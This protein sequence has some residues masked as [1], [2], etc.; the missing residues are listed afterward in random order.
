[1][2]YKQTIR[3]GEVREIAKVGRQIKIINCESTLQLRV[4]LKGENLLDTEVRSGFDVTFSK[5]DSITLQSDQE[6]RIEVWASPNPLGYKAPTKGSNSNLSEIVDH[7]GG[8]QQIL[9]FE[10]NRVAI[11]LFSDTEPFWY[12]GQGV[13]IANGIP[14]AAGVPHKIEGSGEFHI[15]INKPP[16]FGITGVLGDI[17]SEYSALLAD[18]PQIVNNGFIDNQSY[19]VNFFT[20]KY[21]AS[22][23]EFSDLDAKFFASDGNGDLIGV[24]QAQFNYKGQVIT[25][26]TIGATGFGCVNY[27]NGRLFV[28]GWVDNFA[29]IWE[30][31]YATERLILVKTTSLASVRFAY[32][33]FCTLEN[34]L[35]CLAGTN[36]DGYVYKVGGSDFEK[37]ANMTTSME[38]L[39]AIITEADGFLCVSTNKDREIIDKAQSARVDILPSFLYDVSITPEKWVGINSTEVYES[40]DA[41]TSWRLAGDFGRSIGNSNYKP[42]LINVG[43]D[44]YV[45]TNNIPEPAGFALLEQVKLTE[46]AIA[47]IRMLKEVI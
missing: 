44:W 27:S 13:T 28:G 36:G 41:G 46:T 35:F 1:M 25:A 15:A 10:R 40:L 33:V 37:V 29:T 45:T 17:D 22:V 2:L 43:V 11:T 42:R 6:Q 23:F 21:G 18:E 3:A 32:A 38:G 7:Y 31:D 19:R 5:F 30:Y 16:K 26:N 34:E 20:N 39:S 4:F 47:K 8:S 9:P 12:G 14:V 24:S